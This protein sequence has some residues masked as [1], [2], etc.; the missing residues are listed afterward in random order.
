MVTTLAALHAGRKIT[1]LG[2][3]FIFSST[4]PYL[5]LTALLNLFDAGQDVI[6]SR[7]LRQTAELP[8]DDIA[9]PISEIIEERLIRA[10]NPLRVVHDDYAGAYRLHNQP[11]FFIDI[12]L[13]DTGQRRH[14]LEF[15]L[16][17]HHEFVALVRCDLHRAMIE[18]SSRAELSRDVLR[19]FSARAQFSLGPEPQKT[20]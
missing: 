17:H 16:G 4:F 9:F 7:G 15:G 20:Y 14:P 13:V 8:P 19:A 11:Q 10:P 18:Q 2:L 3:F 5:F 12:F 6:V 1:E